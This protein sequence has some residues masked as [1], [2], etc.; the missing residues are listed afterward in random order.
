MKRFSRVTRKRSG[1]G[2]AV[3]RGLCLAASVLALVAFGGKVGTGIS[4]VS[5]GEITAAQMFVELGNWLQGD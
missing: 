5:R 2:R 4:R 1:L 3:V